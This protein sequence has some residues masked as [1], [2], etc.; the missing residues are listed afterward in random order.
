MNNPATV[1]PMAFAANSTMFLLV[2][3][4]VTGVPSVQAGDAQATCSYVDR[5]PGAGQD[6]VRI[7]RHGGC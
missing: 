4:I 3:T 1:S 2:R 7:R 5:P 6:E